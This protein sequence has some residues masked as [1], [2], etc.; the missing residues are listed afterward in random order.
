MAAW[1]KFYVYLS[2]Q[3]LYDVFFAKQRETF[4]KLHV[5]VIPLKEAKE[6][7][8][9]ET[10]EIVDIIAP[11]QLVL[12]YNCNK[13]NFHSRQLKLLSDRQKKVITANNNN[14]NGPSEEVGGGEE[15]DDVT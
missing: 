6:Q 7:A 9:R 1:Q 14:N 13:L 3:Y 2:L 8:T 11:I 4:V 12:L 10:I 5:D 15:D